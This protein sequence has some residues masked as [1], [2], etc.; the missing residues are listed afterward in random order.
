[1]SQINWNILKTLLDDLQ[2]N[3]LIKTKFKTGTEIKRFIESGED[4]YDSLNRDERMKLHFYTYVI[5][6][7]KKYKNKS[8]EQY[9]LMLK[10]VTKF[11]DIDNLFID[12]ITIAW[13]KDFDAFC[14][15][16]GMNQNGRAFY[17]RAIRVIWND[18]ID[19]GLV[20][21]DKYP[22]RRFKIKKADTKHLNMPVDDFRALMFMD[23]NDKLHLERY[24]DLF[25]LSFYLC[26]MNIKDLLFLQK[27]DII[28]NELSVMRIKTNVPVRVKIEPEAQSI[29]NKYKGSKFL[30]NIMDSYQNYEDFRRRM[31]RALKEVFPYISIY[32]ARHSWATYAAEL[33]VPDPIIDMAMGHKLKGMSAIY[34]AR[35]MKKISEANRKV[36]DYV[37]NF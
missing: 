11:C 13:L 26:G 17:L 10:K 9:L 12:D 19:R 21:L 29:F 2:L 16:S 32:W 35:N 27:S 34:V 6:H 36:I 7:A 28:G 4:G 37:H 23:C 33:D 3:G 1:L 8:S 24:R 30:L 14:E 31:N 20:G 22:F 5:N 25:M 18:A 15:L